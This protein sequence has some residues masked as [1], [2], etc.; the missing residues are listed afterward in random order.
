[1]TWRGAVLRWELYS[2]DM[3]GGVGSEQQGARPVLVISNDGFNLAFPVATVVP[4]TRRLGKQRRIYPFEVLLP[5]GTAGNAVDSIVMPY[6]VR[7]IDK[8]R[9]RSR[10]GRLEDQAIRD[11]VEQGLL[12][13]LGIDF[14]RSR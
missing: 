6:Q 13:H 4:L 2:A 11:A 7:T 9:L 1:M 14:E 10:L 5:A 12:E 3:N 8:A